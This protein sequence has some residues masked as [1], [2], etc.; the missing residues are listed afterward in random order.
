MP[1][2][3]ILDNDL[4]ISLPLDGDALGMSEV[5]IENGVNLNMYMPSFSLGGGNNRGE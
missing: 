3:M 4:F 5:I 2:T 1:Y